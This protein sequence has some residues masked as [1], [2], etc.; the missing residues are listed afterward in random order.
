VYVFTVPAGLFMGD[1]SELA[2]QC[3]NRSAAGFSNSLRLDGAK[4]AFLLQQEERGR[5][6]LSAVQYAQPDAK[7]PVVLDALVATEK[8]SVFEYEC[9]V[10]GE[11]GK[12]VVAL[13]RSQNGE[14][15]RILKA[16]IVDADSLH[17]V[18]TK[19]KVSCS[20]LRSA[21]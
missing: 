10:V 5:H 15:S 16:W 3:L 2:A 12:A 11:P 19:R 9:S 7:C 8:T 13:S 6:V 4:N 18:P 21:C 20:D 17:F 1:Q 14:R